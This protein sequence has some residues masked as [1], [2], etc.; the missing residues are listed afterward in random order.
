MNELDDT[1]RGTSRAA[2]TVLVT[3]IVLAQLTW[4]GAI[5]F[6]IWWLVS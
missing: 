6:L 4:I 5:A 1:G 2:S 3:L